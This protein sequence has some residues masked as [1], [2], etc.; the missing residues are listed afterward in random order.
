MKNIF[1]LVLII[2]SFLFAA[3]AKQETKID[4][5]IQKQMEREK[6]YAKEQIFYQAKDYDLKSFE[7]NVD[8]IKSGPV[9][10]IDY[11]DSDDVLDMD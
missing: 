5:E 11:S 7:V 8:A 1:I 4:K 2:N 10:D 9:L 3:D 6:K